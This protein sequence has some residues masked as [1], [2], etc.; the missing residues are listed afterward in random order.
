MGGFA[1]EIQDGDDNFFPMRQRGG[2]QPTRL[3][4]GRNGLSFLGEYNPELIPRLTLARI[5]DKSKGDGLA[6]SLVCFQ[7]EW[8]FLWR[9]R[10]MRGD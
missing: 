7:G 2:S 3:A 10:H 1:F 8:S 6:K 4:I 9:M 5:E